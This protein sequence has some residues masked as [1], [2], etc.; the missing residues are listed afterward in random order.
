MRE[1][2]FPGKVR[3]ISFFNS[4]SSKCCANHCLRFDENKKTISYRSGVRLPAGHIF[5]AEGT[6][7]S[8]KLI[9]ARAASALGAD[10]LSQSFQTFI[11]VHCLLLLAMNLSAVFVSMF[12]LTKNGSFRVVAMFY[13]FAY[14]FEAVGYL[15]ANRLTLR[16]NPVVLSRWGLALYTASYIALLI[17]RENSSRHYF[18]VA[19]FTGLGAGLYW[20]PYHR[21]CVEFSTLSTRQVALS[22]MGI[23]SNFIILAAPPLS[24]FIISRLQS[25]G[26][27][28][29][30][31]VSVLSFFASAFV[32]RK[33]SASNP[34]PLAARPGFFRRS[35]MKSKVLRMISYAELLRGAR[36]GV[37]LFYLNILIYSMTSNEFVIAL[38]ITA[39]GLSLMLIFAL[40]GRRFTQKSRNTALI[41]CG[42]LAA[43]L[44]AGLY[45]WFTWL[46]VI[47]YSVIDFAVYNLAVNSASYIC[48]AAG[49]TFSGADKSGSS[50]DVSA[51]RCFALNVGRVLGTLVLL[52]F[53]LSG[54]DMIPVFIVLNMLA[55]LGYT[56]Y[57]ITAKLIEAT[58]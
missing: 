20:L 21:F 31:S 12:L 34:K 14:A 8:V 1:K 25:G 10:Q 4:F 38:S 18:I 17:M 28:I 48:Y 41:V 47:I 36:D 52:A 33:L 13:L 45:M 26:Y 49:E 3:G 5:L 56:L 7:K 24:G 2:A 16:F 23:A 55:L 42:L 37:F 6:V 53:P 40:I 19:V 35:F 46:S 43:A 22:V 50:D 39:R 29:V 58:L 54:K 44:P 27:M 51:M 30:F 15:L 9:F 57:Y 11:K 32:S